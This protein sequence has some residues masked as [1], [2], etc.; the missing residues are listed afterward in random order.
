[1]PAK[2]DRES[3]WLLDRYGANA[4]GLIKY[5]SMAFGQPHRKSVH[6]FWII[7]RDLRAFHESNADFYR[8][9]LNHPSTSEEQVRRNRFAPNFY[10]FRDDDV[11][12]KA[13]VLSEADFARLCRS[14]MMFVKGRMQKPLRMIRTTPVI[15][16]AIRDAREEG[17]RQAV[18]L[19][20]SRFTL[21]EFLYQLCSLSYRA[22]IR[23]ERKRA[24]IQSI[25]D[26]GGRR[27]RDMYAALLVGMEGLRRDGRSYVSLRS[28]EERK[29]L[30]K[31][32][33]GYLRR[34]KWSMDTLRLIWRNYR[35]HSSPLRYIW[36]KLVGEAE[37]AGRRC[38]ERAAPMQERHERR[39]PR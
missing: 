14:K 20:A 30:R 7:V 4:V 15:D 5:G 39:A 23:P 35:T 8:T 22:E 16:A 11:A 18:N 27:L 37:K 2:L 13:A 9:E 28:A 1:M 38:R 19:C 24:K 31:R 26:S 25:I 36:D 33:L 32:T 17:A 34:C 21:R 10:F 12:I 29:M 3:T 6:D